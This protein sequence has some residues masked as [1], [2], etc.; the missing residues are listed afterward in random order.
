MSFVFRP[1]EIADVIEITP[2]VHRDARGG[3]A[4]IFKMSEFQT[5]GIEASF[6]QV[7]Y[8]HS[9]KGVL[10]GLHYQKP[11]KAQAKL[12][13]VGSGEIFDVAIDIRP[14]SPT[15]KQWVGVNLSSEKKNML[16][17]PAGLAHGFQVV[18]DMAE[19]MYFVSGS[20]YAPDFETGIIWNDPSLN[21]PWPI[22][23][24]VLSE[25][26]KLYSTI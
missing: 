10:R 11:P 14:A 9:G 20:E 3:F 13:A 12:M 18:S 5:H 26:D 23:Q 4:E 6:V 19:V 17:V 24:P 21:I 22:T 25:K 8:S 16:W 7:N 2:Q 15:Y 1:T